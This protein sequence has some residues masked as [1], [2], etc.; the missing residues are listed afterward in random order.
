[1]RSMVSLVLLLCC[2]NAVAQY[3]VPWFKIAGGG[4]V[5]SAGQWTVSGT[6]GQVDPDV[7][8]LCSQDGTVPGLCEGASVK[9]SGGF[10][11]GV[12]PDGTP[13]SCGS[14]L[15]CIFRNGFEAGT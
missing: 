15:A 13:S 11:M 7:V 12:Q 4:G 6:V 5:S 10:W 2:G 8:P 1:M 3:E 9:L 14:D